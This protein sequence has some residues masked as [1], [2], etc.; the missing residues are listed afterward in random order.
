L[1]KF[2]NLRRLHCHSNGL[3]SLDVSKNT[4]IVELCCHNDELSQLNLSN[5]DKIE[6]L[7]CFK[8]KLSNLD[9]TNCYQL[10]AINCSRNQLTELIL[11]NRLDNLSKLRCRDNL[12]T[13]F[14]FSPLNKEKLII[15]NLMNNNL[16][17]KDLSC[18][19]CFTKIEEL[20]IGTV[21]QER[22]NKGVYNHWVGSLKPLKNLNQL[23]K[24]NISNTEI[25]EGI[26][27]LPSNIKE[28][29]CSNSEPMVKQIEK[30][31]IFVPFENG[32]I[33]QE[34]KLED[35]VIEQI[36]IFDHHC[37]NVE[38]KLLVDRLISDRELNYRYK[39]YGLCKRCG[40][41]SSGKCGEWY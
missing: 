31:G 33:K 28:I 32:Y 34:K 2:P 17:L 22:F 25:N 30:L 10:T 3:T 38:Q 35:N 7:C 6:I 9:L 37:L 36:K 40:Q 19:S 5:C 27:H 23:E 41:P 12:L 26:E 4:Q 11:P 21:D 29:D 8:N 15:F 18:F 14:D 24:L 39:Q 16:S 13:S 20:Y 1:G